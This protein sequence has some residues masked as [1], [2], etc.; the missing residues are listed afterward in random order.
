VKVQTKDKTT[1][2]EYDTV[3]NRM[4]MKV[5]T[6][7]DTNLT[8]YSYNADNQLLYYTVNGVNTILFRYDIN[9]NLIKK[10]CARYFEL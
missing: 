10:Y 3:G 1:E 5:L 2:Y 4:Q 8:N 9:V 6:T 7:N